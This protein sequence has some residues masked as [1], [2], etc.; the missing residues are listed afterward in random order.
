MFIRTE[1]DVTLAGDEY[2]D[3][4]PP[5]FSAAEVLYAFNFRYGRLAFVTEREVSNFPDKGQRYILSSHFLPASRIRP[6]K[7]F[8]ERI[9]V[10]E[11]QTS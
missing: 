7:F 9:G 5:I 3:L 10:T 1:P 6:K 2:F 8:D 11:E 4:I